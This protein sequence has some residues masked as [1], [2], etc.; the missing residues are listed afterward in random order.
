MA[1]GKAGEAR[2][3]EKPAW[4]KWTIEQCER[5]RISQGKSRRAARIA[6]V[7]IGAV[8]GAAIGMMAVGGRGSFSLSA[9]P[10][11]ASDAAATIKF[12]N[13]HWT[14]LNVM[15][16]AHQTLTIEVVNA[17]NETIE[18]ESFKLNRETAMTPG[19]TIKV[20][21]P[22]LSP[23]TYD[24]YDDFHQDVPQGTIVAK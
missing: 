15:V 24:F 2:P 22:A 11:A 3:K 1:T 12:E 16:P 21:L 20:P 4:L 9:A 7:A 13:H 23:G 5:A 6:G 17:S 14:P 8:A 19:Q 10:V 18:F